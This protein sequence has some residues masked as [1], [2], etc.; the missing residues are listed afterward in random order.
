LILD[1][2]SLVGWAAATDLAS[3][4]RVTADSAES[5]VARVDVSAS[6]KEA[7][8]SIISSRAE[9][10]AVCDGDKFLGVLTAASISKQITG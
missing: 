4:D 10:T 5:L 2:G 3:L 7:L 6:L 1:G 8:D 9:F